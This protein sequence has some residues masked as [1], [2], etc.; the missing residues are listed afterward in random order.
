M[1][2]NVHLAKLKTE[3]VPMFVIVL[4]LANAVDEIMLSVD[5]RI[6]TVK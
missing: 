1:F 3:T 5:I 4:L 2:C 6:W